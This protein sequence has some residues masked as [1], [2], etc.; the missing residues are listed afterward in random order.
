[1]SDGLRSTVFHVV[2]WHLKPEAGGRSRE[3][4]ALR[5]R[6]ALETLRP[7][8]GIEELRVGIDRRRRA[9]SA[10]VVMIG[11]FTDQD[12][13]EAYHEHPLHRAILPLVDEIRERSTVVDFAA[14]PP[15]APPDPA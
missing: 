14:S 10:D 6:D 2:M 15:G 8:P 12:A 13:L 9:N 11:R 5:L 3:E 7:I 1:M 4:N